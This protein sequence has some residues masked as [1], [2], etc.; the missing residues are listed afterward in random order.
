MVCRSSFGDI[1]FFLNMSKIF[2]AM[3]VI[4]ARPI[5]D[6]LAIEKYAS[7]RLELKM[8]EI[9]KTTFL[10]HVSTFGIIYSLYH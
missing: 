3:I 10:Y 4:E 9:T 5:T 8:Y 7:S 1:R 2:Y 6:F